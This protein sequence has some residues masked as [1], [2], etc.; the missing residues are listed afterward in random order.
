MSGGATL[1][2][3]EAATNVTI[4]AN[5]GGNITYRLDGRITSASVRNLTLS[6]TVASSPVAARCVVIDASGKAT[7]RTDTDNNPANGCN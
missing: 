3:R 6:T 1:E 4:T 2:S 5:A 7:I